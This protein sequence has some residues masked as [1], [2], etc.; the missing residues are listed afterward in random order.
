MYIP[1]DV[2]DDVDELVDIPSDRLIKSNDDREIL[3]RKLKSY[4]R[5]RRGAWITIIWDAILTTTDELS[6]TVEATRVV[7]KKRR[8]DLIYIGIPLSINNN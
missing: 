3:K 5:W 1:R 8:E 4:T 7:E 6:S 2:I